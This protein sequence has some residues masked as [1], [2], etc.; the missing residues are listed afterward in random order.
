M[1][2]RMS[3][4][5][6]EMR[7]VREAARQTVLKLDRLVRAFRQARGASRCS[8]AP[9][10]T[11]TRARPSRSLVPRVPENRRCCTLPGCSRQPT[12]AA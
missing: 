10:P 12:A 5:A 9:A 1:S 4:L 11:F 7:P 2:D 3:A 6:Q 8:R